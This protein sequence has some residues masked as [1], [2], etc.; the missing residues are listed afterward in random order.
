MLKMVRQSH[1]KGDVTRGND[2]PEEYIGVG[3]DHAMSFDTKDVVD[4]AVEG[5][6]FNVREKTQNGE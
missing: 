4:L 3:N 6:I 5:T 2:H 1:V